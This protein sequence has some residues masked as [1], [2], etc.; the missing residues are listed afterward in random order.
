[1]KIAFTAK[2]ID[3]DAQID[4][5][6]GR[7]DYI[8]VYD[9]EADTLTNT[10]NREVEGIAHGAGPQTAQKLFDLAPDVLITGN[11]PGGNAAAALQKAKLKIFTGAGGMT[12][13]E[14]FEAY[15][16]GSLQDFS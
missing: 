10:D 7:T 1:M 4:P 14:A 8:V 11:G 2:G 3:W 9:E 5:R 15:K 13:K 16:K 6:F 12:V